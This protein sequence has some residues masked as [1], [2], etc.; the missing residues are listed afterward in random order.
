[1]KELSVIQRI[2]LQIKK[3]ATTERVYTLAHCDYSFSSSY[4]ADE[5]E[6]RTLDVSFSG[7]LNNKIDT[8]FLEWLSNQPGEWSGTLKIYYQNQDQPVL[9]FVFDNAIANNYSQ[10]FS[11]NNVH[12]QD[13]YFSAVLKGVVLNNIKMN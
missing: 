2:E 11:E 6:K 5:A 3:D 10:S 4:F 8:F 1:M 7:T 9:D 13:A 12:N